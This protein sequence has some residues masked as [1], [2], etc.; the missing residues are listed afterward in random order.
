MQIAASFVSGRVEQIWDSS[1][2]TEHCAN[3]ISGSSKV[4]QFHRKSI[5]V[6]AGYS[7]LRFLHVYKDMEPRLTL[8]E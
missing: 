3:A 4:K 5:S 2:G 6:T 7:F 1:L 8:R